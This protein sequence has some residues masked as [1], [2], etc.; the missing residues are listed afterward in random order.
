[1]SETGNGFEIAII[2]MAGRFPGA[3]SLRRFW[4]NLCDGVE[5]IHFFTDEE[6]IA[7]GVDPGLLR[8]PGYVRARPVLDDVDLFDA[9]FFGFSAREAEMLDPQHRLFL[10]TA[11][12]AL[13]DGG[14]AGERFGPVTGVYG[15]AGANGY[16]MGLVTHPGGALA[17]PLQTLL[18]NDK[19]YLATRVSYKLGLEGPSVTVQTACSTSLVSIHL[20]CQGLLGGECDLALAGGVC[21]RVPQ[22]TGYLFSEGEI[23][24]PD[25][26]CR[27]FD[28]SARGTNFGSGVGVVLLKR[29]SD[30]LADGD[31]IRA[32]IKGS[33]VN[34]DGSVR[35]GYTAPRAETQARVIRSAQALGGVSPASIG[36]IE[37][38]GTGTPLGDPIE[39]EALGKVFA[40]S[41]PA[42]R[43]AIGSVKTNIGHLETAAGMAGLIK[44]VFALESGLLPPS[45]HFREPNPEIDFAG[46]PFRVNTELRPWTTNGSPRRAGVSS[47][48]IGGTNAHVV[49][50]EAPPAPPPAPSRPW[51]VLFLSARSATALEAAGR[52][53]AGHLESCSGAELPDVAYTLHAGRRTFEHRRAV[54]CRDPRE[55]AKALTTLDPARVVSAVQEAADR[56]VAFLFPGQGAQYA[57]MARGLYADEPGFREEVERCAGLAARHVGLD[58]L[59]QLYPPAGTAADRGLRDTAT[60]QPALF[61]VEYALA[62][63]WMRWGLRPQALIGHSLGEYVAACL[64]GVLSLEEAISLVA[65]RGRLM[66]ELEPGAMLSV[67][68]AEEETRS[69]LGEDLALAAVNGPSLCVVSGALDPIA[70][71]E[72]RLCGDGLD[73]RRLHTS[74]AFHSRLMDPILER[75]ARQVRKVRLEAPQIPYLSNLT[76]TWIRPEEATDPDYWVRHLRRTVRFGSGLL[77]LFERPETLLLEVGPGRTLTTLAKRH[78]DRPA[79]QTALASLPRPTDDAA[80]D[81]PTLLTAVAHLRLAGVP[82]E[83]EAFFAGEKRRRVPLPT[84]PF[85]RRRYWLE[86]RPLPSVPPPPADLADWFH[87]PSWRRTPW[88]ARSSGGDGRPGPW[89]IFL[90]GQGVGAALADRAA[91]DRE[92]VRVS[93]GLGFARQGGRD[94]T[95]RPGVAEDIELLLEELG[96]A[97]CAPDRIV[98]AWSIAAGADPSVLES[99]FYSLLA[100][101]RALARRPFGHRVEIVLLSTGVQ[102]VTGDEELSPETAALL[103]PCRVIPQELENVG[104]RSIDLAP[105]RTSSWREDRL[106]GRLF[107]EI[108]Q[109]SAEPVVAYRGAHRWVQ[110]FEPLRMPAGTKVPLRDGAAVL[111][112]GGTGGIGLSLARR[113][114]EEVK[115]VR[116]ALLSRGG[117]ERHG[118][119]LCELEALGAEV[120]AVSADVTDVDALR[121]AVGTVRERFGRIDVVVH[122]AGVPGGGLMALRTREQAE[123]V[124]A[125]KIAGARAL[126]SVFAHEPP[127]LLVLCS[128]TIAVTGG[129]GQA[130]YCAANNVLDTFAAFYA[131]RYGVSAVAI[132]W[133]RWLEVGMAARAHA[134]RPAGR[135]ARH[136]LLGVWTDESPRLRVCEARWSAARD[137]FLAE[138]RVLDRPVV[139]GT[140]YLEL[141]R[142]A[143][144]EAEGWEACELREMTFVSPLAA[145]PGGEVEVRVT[146]RDG[147]VGTEITIAGREAESGA[148]WREHAVGHAVP[149]APESRRHAL[150]ELRSRCRGESLEAAGQ[151]GRRLVEWGPRW[152]SLREA[153]WNGE[154]GFAH[155]ELPEAFADDCARFALHPALVDVATSFVVGAAA[156]GG[157]LPFYYKSLR[158]YGSPLPRRIF[159][160]AVRRAAVANSDLLELDVTILDEEGR[161]LVG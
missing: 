81:L 99:S 22:K 27:T 115:G 43:C 121:R 160:H 29:L 1:M 47:F 46:G 34:N 118:P 56:P 90:D 49:L 143:L 57:G 98:H 18:A 37:A 159:S 45:L 129:A 7:A 58:L 23:Y 80:E 95:I 4:Q 68:L 142:A 137:W 127:D 59:A 28:A 8:R 123:R 60:A 20:A 124:L 96:A 138:H 122:A 161:E 82:I 11:W 150:A 71:L 77:R 38:H 64:A 63:L 116:L 9:R 32:V 85:E 152:G 155:L 16:L 36:Y 109:A 100:L 33:A 12:Q 126:E 106:I 135:P 103:G 117:L 83:A 24:S 74:H 3:P 149:V 75:F 72:S 113:L 110:S 141:A 31:P 40:G 107:A 151:D 51:Q 48:G 21:I 94:Y 128:S 88:P 26:H 73:C 15:G 25:G 133:D 154:E 10:E 101:A 140:V 14:Y 144:E 13:E 92:V 148:P 67:P 97:G 39:M 30:A 145:R 79:A 86:P 61:I 158:W 125:P 119:A 111:I 55:G 134:G 105:P 130:D 41:R 17:S 19:D 5:S 91:A 78:P 50:E 69:L 87:L 104:C 156:T 42:G 131:S 6:L 65:V 84:Y 70:R 136:P 102:E 76:G 54:V 153:W 2:G 89:L 132:D 146:L 93:R 35:A 114:A 44:T 120:L 147:E 66:Q 108:E 112:T 53:L 157:F 139:P 62:K 52:D